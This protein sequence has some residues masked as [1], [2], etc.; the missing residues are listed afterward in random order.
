MLYFVWL[1]FPGV[2]LC[3]PITRCVSVPEPAV[4]HRALLL[5]QMFDFAGSEHQ[6]HYTDQ[7]SELFHS[8]V[9]DLFVQP[10]LRQFIHWLKSL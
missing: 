9:D 3:G 6:T 7:N 10:N 8:N 4:S 2:V 5:F 1:H